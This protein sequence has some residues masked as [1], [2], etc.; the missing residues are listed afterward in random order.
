MAEPD[1]IVTLP[2]LLSALRFVA[3][4]ALV[5]L[6]WNGHHQ[7]YLLV[8]VLSFASDVLD[9]LVARLLKKESTLGALLD[10]SADVVMYIT[11]PITAW[12][13]WPDLV[14]QEA[15]YVVVIVASYTLPMIVGLLKFGVFTS[16]HTWGVKLA[17]AATGCS[18]LLMFAGGPPW[19]FRLAAFICLL[20]AI[21][22]I[23]IT[24]VLDER[25][26]NVRTL[27]H[28][29]QRLQYMR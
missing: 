29:L 5:V 1:E 17:A 15:P 26:S 3:A 2:N 6:A 27:W 18:A 7:T 9:G 19:P 20:A 8:L 28:V 23:A 14:R 25:Q 16:Y 24:I 22:Q 12:W 11:I 13:L 10:S 4:P 21:E